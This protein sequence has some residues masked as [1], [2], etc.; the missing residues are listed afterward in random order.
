[1]AVPWALCALARKKRRCVIAQEDT[2][3]GY[4]QWSS[5]LDVPWKRGRDRPEQSLHLNF[6]TT[7]ISLTKYSL[8]SFKAVYYQSPLLHTRSLAVEACATV[9]QVVIDPAY[10]RQL[11]FRSS[12]FASA[13][14]HYRAGINRMYVGLQTCVAERLH[15]FTFPSL[16]IFYLGYRC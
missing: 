2:V 15:L 9:I 13:I 16:H 1:M 14:V 4:N 6:R 10:V 7:Y 5:P 3:P 12:E 11:R 8:T